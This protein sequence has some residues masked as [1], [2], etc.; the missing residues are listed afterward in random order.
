MAVYVWFIGIANSVVYSVLVPLSE[1]TGLSVGD[2]NAGTG[3]L[4][5]LAGWGLLISEKQGSKPCSILWPLTFKT[6]SSTFRSAVWETTNVLDV[7]ACNS[8]D[9]N[10]G[11]SSK[12]ERP[13]DREKYSWWILRFSHRGASGD[14]RGRRI[15]RS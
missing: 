2:L 7:H 10:M 14:I 12:G 6:S 8:G 1:S 13:M 9:L 15:F 3:Y 11:C 5:L 4:F